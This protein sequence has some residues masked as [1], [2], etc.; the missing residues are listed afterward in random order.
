MST[1]I[2][3][4]FLNIQNIRTHL[5]SA[6]DSGPAVLLLHGGG[7]DSARLSWGAAIQPIS[8]SWRVFAPDW[9]GYGDSQRPDIRY[10]MAFFTAFL[11]DLLDALSLERVSLAGVS[12]GGGIAISFCLAHPERVEKL[13]LIDSYGLQGRAPMH[14]LSSLFVQIPLLTEMTY[15]T[16]KLSRSLTRASLSSIFANPKTAMTDE[17]VDLVYAEVQKPHTGRAFHSFQMDEV[18]WDGLRSVFMDRLGEIQAPTLIIHGEVDNLVPLECSKQ[19][20][21]RIHGSCLEILPDCGHWPQRE[22]PELFNRL[23]KEFLA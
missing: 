12:M 5:F 4:Q 19:A 15:A 6:G 17:L 1:T 7:V 22:N 3:S 13:V 14:Q 16:L 9:P 11:T 23:L 8:D 2:S 21:Q 20:Q 10:N 18:G